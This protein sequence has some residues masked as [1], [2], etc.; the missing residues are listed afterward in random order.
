MR[1]RR[2]QIP[3]DEFGSSGT[4]RD[5]RRASARSRRASALGAAGVIFSV[6]FRDDADGRRGEVRGSA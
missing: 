4:T 3:H 1:N 6:D 5:P 2:V